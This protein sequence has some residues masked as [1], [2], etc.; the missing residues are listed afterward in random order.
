MMFNLLLF[1]KKCPNI[2]RWDLIKRLQSTAASATI[3]VGER[4]LTFETGRLAKFADGAVVVKQGETS[5]LVTVVSKALQKPSSFLPL[6]VDYRL[7]AAAAGRIPMNFYRRERGITDN[8]ILTSRVIDRSIRPLFPEDCQ[9][10]LQVICNV[11]AVDGE[12]DPAVLAINAASFAT[13]LSKT[14]WNG[15][16]GAVRV[17]Y[18]DKEFVINPLRHELEKSDI[19]L[20]VTS[21]LQGIVMLE[22]GANNVNY[23]LMKQAINIGQQESMKVIKCIQD[24]IEKSSIFKHTASTTKNFGDALQQEI[25][26][27]VKK[28]C[29]NEFLNILSNYSHDKFSRDAAIKN[30]MKTATQAL[31]G[32]YPVESSEIFD[33]AVQK[34]FK[35]VF[36]SK[37][38]D[39]SIRCDGRK[40]T[41][42]R[43]ISCSVDVLKPLHGSSLFQRGQTQVLSTM[44]YDSLDMSLKYDPVS[45]LI[46]G[47]K[48]KNFMLHYEFP[49]YATNE[50]GRPG[51]ALA[52]RE[53]GHGALAERGLR[54]IIPENYPFTLRVTAEVLESNG[55]SSM[56]SVC[57][58]SL[59]LMDAG[60]PVKEAAAGVAIGL[61]SRSNNQGKITEYRVLTDLLGIEDYC[62]DMDF[63][64]AGTRHGITALQ[65]DI[66]LEG[67]PLNIVNEAINAGKRGISQILDIMDNV[68]KSPRTNKTNTPVTEKFVIN[69]K[70]RIRIMGVGGSKIRE[71]AQKTGV[72]MSILDESTMELFAPDKTALQEGKEL[73][74]AWL[75]EK[76]A[77]NM[78]FGAIYTV[79]IL[80]I[81]MS[82]A[83]VEI[84]PS[85]EP[86]F[87]H[88]RQLDLRSV[89]DARVL[90]FKP[91][92]EIQVKY[93]G[94]DP[95]SGQVRLSRR[96]LLTPASQAFQ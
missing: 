70:K 96:L 71:L 56:A 31:T 26:T 47:A 45:Q 52:R 90:G 32:I 17:G 68:L 42:L 16:V 83:L 57:G 80:E 77:P 81:D 75:E 69:P 63:K 95:I 86:V 9:R 37:I 11:L 21:S 60:V 30:S 5:V 12:N 87:I 89:Q 46:S 40:L 20:I 3:K 27:E 22:G 43:N 36:R 84:H 7:K 66:K 59:A 50:I 49:P 24:F 29:G 33:S 51:A 67:L 1:C 85:L 25:M 53:I 19:N 44:A 74:N 91:G 4:D 41:D 34:C 14:P 54:P 62:G 10:E 92:D 94:N 38:L 18:L 73:L 55:S 13:A 58:G 8:E 61:V 35:E 65:A 78:E 15:P 39:T 72:Q 64:M 79:K 2:K 82:G 88:R 23:D 76:P 6:T 93:F 48:E 28:I